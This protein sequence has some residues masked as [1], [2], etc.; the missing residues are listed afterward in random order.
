ME[1]KKV[2]NIK[3]R[4]IFKEIKKYIYNFIG[5]LNFYVNL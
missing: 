1:I 4:N 3:K 2:Q 5:K